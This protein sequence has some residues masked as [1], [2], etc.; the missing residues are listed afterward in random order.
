MLTADTFVKLYKILDSFLD[1]ETRTRIIREVI[2]LSM[3]IEF[4]EQ[5]LKNLEKQEQMDTEK[6][7]MDLKAAEIAKTM[8]QKG[9]SID[10]IVEITKLSKEK[11]EELKSEKWVP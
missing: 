2:R 5:E 3:K 9:I 6:F 11:I 7:Y 1:D 10:D 4:T 8:L